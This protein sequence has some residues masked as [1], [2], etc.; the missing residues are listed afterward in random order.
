MKA[1][2]D[3]YKEGELDT[4]EFLRQRDVLVLAANEAQLM[5]KLT[6]QAA[7]QA[8]DR[9]IDIFMAENPVYKDP[10]V[11]GALVAVYQQEEFLE[12]HGQ[13][14]G[15]VLLNEAK[16]VVDQRF[17]LNAQKEEP[18]EEPLTEKELIAKKK[19]AL[20]GRGKQA[21]EVPQTLADVPSASESVEKNK[22]SALDD[23]EGFDLE[24]AIDAMSEEDQDSW[25]RNQH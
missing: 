19:D 14:S 2:E 25:L 23:L 16:K 4:T 12:K 7:K 10:L 5:E 17:N 9:D 20:K 11:A 6:A 18:K 22:F 8:W 3:K 21:A 24:K 15:Y 13:K 1:L